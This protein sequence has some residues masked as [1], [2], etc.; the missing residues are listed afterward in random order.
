[1]RR[2]L[3][4]APVLHF[5]G[6]TMASMEA[7]RPRVGYTDLVN[8][9]EDG[10]RYEI[11]E[12]E[13]FVVPSPLPRHQMVALAVYE[14]LRA[15]AAASGGI[16]LA[17]PLDIVFDEYDVIQPDVLFFRAD[18]RHHVRP[19]AAIRAAPDI[20]AEVLSPSTAA[21]DRGRKM[22]TFARYGVSEV[23][24][25]DPVGE[26]IEVYSLDGTS[27]RRAQVAGA[28]DAVRSILLPELTF[29]VAAVFRTV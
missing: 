1:M 2:R 3:P 6:D 11:H 24:I 26:Q 9:P 7:V 16:A 22:Q 21:T 4:L 12:G 18:R 23:W 29:V 13:V 19:D 10:R 15:F 25:A 28:D 20:V 8:T 27:Y 5:V 17:A 14:R